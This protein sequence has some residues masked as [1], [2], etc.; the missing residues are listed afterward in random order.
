[1]RGD[2]V[3]TVGR[4]G[5]TRNVA[6]CDAGGDVGSGEHETTVRS[7]G[8][9]RHVSRWNFGEQAFATEVV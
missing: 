8:S 7:A 5:L 9:R 3:S 4:S 2:H 6:T 1:M